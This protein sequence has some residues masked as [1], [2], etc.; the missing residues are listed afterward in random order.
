MRTTTAGG[1][2]RDAELLKCV[3]HVFPIAAAPAFEWLCS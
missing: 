1:S 2:L 3:F